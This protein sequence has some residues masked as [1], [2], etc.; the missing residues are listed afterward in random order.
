MRYCLQS[1]AL[2]DTSESLGSLIAIALDIAKDSGP[3]MI[4]NSEGKH[5]FSAW[6]IPAGV[7]WRAWPDHP[8]EYAAVRGAWDEWSEA[9]PRDAA[10]GVC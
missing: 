2:M 4:R 8:G 1:D 7:V 9:N 3:A 6:R 10:K 5:V